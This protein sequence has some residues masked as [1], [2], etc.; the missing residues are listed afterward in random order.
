MYTRAHA[1][2]HAYTQKIHFSVC[3]FVRFCF[4]KKRRE[5]TIIFQ[6]GKSSVTRSCV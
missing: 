1:R 4:D 3:V 6:N 2:V 5:R